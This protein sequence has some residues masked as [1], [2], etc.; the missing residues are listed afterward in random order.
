[1]A[2][3]EFNENLAGLASMGQFG[4]LYDDIVYIK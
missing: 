3:Y 4:G 2:K 1:M